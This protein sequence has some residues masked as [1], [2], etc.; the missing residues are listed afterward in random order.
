MVAS[1]HDASE[2][3][4]P[5]VSRVW[6][7]WM[8]RDLA[9]PSGP[10]WAAVGG[11]NVRPKDRRCQKLLLVRMPNSS[12]QL[13]PPPPLHGAYGGL[14]IQPLA[15]RPRALGLFLIPS[16]S[17]QPSRSKLLSDAAGAV[18]S[19]TSSDL[20]N[21]DDFFWLTLLHDMHLSFVPGWLQLVSLL[22]FYQPSHVSNC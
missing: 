15:C 18:S 20:I 22:L 21:P 4:L 5:S 9:A 3:A 17:T 13:A 7:V 19:Y 16:L 1:G 10:R 2:T 6:A 14:D 12:F 11:H 8:A